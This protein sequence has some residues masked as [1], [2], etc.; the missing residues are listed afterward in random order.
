MQQQSQ[1]EAIT[2]GKNIQQ[3]WKQSVHTQRNY[4][5]HMYKLWQIDNT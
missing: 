5:L 3:Y 1:Q 2:V 4:Y